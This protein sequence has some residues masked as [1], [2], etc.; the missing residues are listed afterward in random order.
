MKNEIKEYS[1]DPEKSDQYYFP[2]STRQF[3]SLVGKMLTHIEAMNL[4]ERS[5]KANKDIVRQN[6]W[7]WWERAQENS[8]TSAGLCIGPIYAPNSTG[9]VTSEPHQWLTE[10]GVIYQPVSENV[11]V[12]K[13]AKKVA[14]HIIW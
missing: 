8:L 9:V 5:E 3:E 6:M 7:T 4:S 11:E 1:I 2:V 13:I 14:K 12:Q 10:D